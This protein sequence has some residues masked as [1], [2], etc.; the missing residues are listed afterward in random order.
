MK[1]L[2]S[3]YD[4]TLTCGGI[5]EM[6]IAAIHKWREA[7]N[8]FGIVTGRV[9]SFRQ[10]LLEEK[11]GFELDFY[12]ACNGGYITDGEGNLIYEARCTEIAAT[13]LANSLFECEGCEFLNVI[14]EKHYYVI[15]KAE[16][17][18]SY[19]TEDK[20][21]FL[22]KM[23]PISYL[24]Q[25]G[26]KFGSF[27]QAEAA[28]EAMRKLYGDFLTPLQNGIFIDVVPKGVNKAEGMYR[29]MEFFGGKYEDVITVGDNINDTDM[30]REFR[31]YA[32]ESGVEYVKALADGIVSNVTEIFEKEM[33][34]S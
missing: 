26:V 5:E 34:V 24:N 10:R 15:T 20:A 3:D 13:E 8:R 17:R 23:P 4:G 7:G 30:L 29:V 32:M 14:C 18:P 31:S 2:G 12:V 1:I 19:V 6:K 21:F 33:A 28:A 9:A 25:I 11:E 16:N 22:E 27:E